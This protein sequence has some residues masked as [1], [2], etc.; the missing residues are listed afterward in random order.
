MGKLTKKFML[1]NLRD[2]KILLSLSMFY[3]SFESLYGLHQ[4]P[5]PGVE[6]TGEF[7]MSALDELTFFLGISKLKQKP[8][9]S[10]SDQKKEN[11]S[12]I[13]SPHSRRIFKYLKAN[14]ELGYG[15]QEILFLCWKHIVISDYRFNMVDRET[16]TG[17]ISVPG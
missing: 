13:G 3:K 2:L 5:R 16:T 14:Q 11:Q 4:A 1:L 15:T 7:E 12:M 8:V 10:L 17:S 9:G 6:D